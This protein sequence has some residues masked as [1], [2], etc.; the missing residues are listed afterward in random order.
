V[1]RVA[2]VSELP[3]G[4]GK[5]IDCGDRRVTVYNVDGRFYAS[6]SRVAREREPASDCAQ[7]GLTFDACVEDSP[8]RL[9]ADQRACRVCVI[10]N[11]LWVDVG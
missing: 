8:A 3:P 2:S 6:S 10:A 9:R 1:I 7:H 11:V 4:K 5:V